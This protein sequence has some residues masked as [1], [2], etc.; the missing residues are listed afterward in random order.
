MLKSMPE[1]FISFLYLGILGLVI[2]IAVGFYIREFVFC[3]RA[4]FRCSNEPQSLI[5]S[6]NMV[7]AV[8]DVK[9]G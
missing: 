2:L 4:D 9:S 3:L 8:F 5:T 1:N 7:S 6:P